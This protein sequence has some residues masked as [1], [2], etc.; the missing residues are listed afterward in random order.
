MKE[1]LFE[2]TDHFYHVNTFEKW[3]FGLQVFTNSLFKLDTLEIIALSV[4]LSNGDVH[5]IKFEFIFFMKE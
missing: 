3:S 5:S 4:E 2:V 1:H